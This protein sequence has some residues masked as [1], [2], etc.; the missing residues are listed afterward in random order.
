MNKD[1][2]DAVARAAGLAEDILEE[3]AS[4]TQDWTRVA[5][6]AREL[7]ELAA[8]LA[9]SPPGGTGAAPA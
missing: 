7:M 9:G 3:V 1:Y 8:E 4:A 5:A 2:E 6:W